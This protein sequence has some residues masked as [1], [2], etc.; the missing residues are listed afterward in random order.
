M[1]QV[2]KIL[3]IAA[4]TLLGVV[5]FLLLYLGLGWLGGQ[6]TIGK[7]PGN[8]DVAIYIKTNGVHTDIVVPARTPQ[9]DWTREFKYANT[10]LHD[11][12]WNY[13]GL[14][15]G[16]KGFY[17]QTPTWADLKFSVAFKATFGL[18]PSALHATYYRQMVE[19]KT[20]RKIWLSK[21]QYD[22]LVQY[23]LS[24]LQKGPDGHSIYIK[25]NANYSISDAFYEGTGRYNLFYTCN[26]WANNALRACGQKHCLWALT[27]RSIFAAYDK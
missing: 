27:D 24:S 3:R 12:T 20:C 17:L 18:S 26:S 16:D 21:E 10:G 22:H 7:E 5:C 9:A 25:T 13:L 6:I 8:E 2:K 4:K 1:P 11:T 23:I 15:W 19:N 14:G